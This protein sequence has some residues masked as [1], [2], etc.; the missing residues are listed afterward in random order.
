M[1]AAPRRAM[2]LAAGRGER[3]RPLTDRLPKPLVAVGG[4]ALIDHVLDGLATAGVGEAIVNLWYKSDMIAAHL[5]ERRRPRVTLSRETELLDTGGGV[6]KALP[7]LGPGP[8]YVL[9]SDAL[10]RDGAT[11]ALE[12]LAAAWDDA[13]MDALLLLQP[14]AKAVGFDGAGDFDLDDGGR[15]HRRGDAAAAPFAFMSI[16]MLHPR[17]YRGCPS[18]VFSNNVI[19]DRA[20]DAGRLFGLVHDGGW[21]HVGTVADI[22][23]AE[24]WLAAPN[25]D[26]T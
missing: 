3:M 17:V 9:S 25:D 22:A 14:M 18:G 6:A 19:W 2:V 21:C 24:R 8:F 13:T 16:Q 20:L 7:A 11:P 4:K 12:R 5:A 26:A 15:L 1:S 10:W 23:P